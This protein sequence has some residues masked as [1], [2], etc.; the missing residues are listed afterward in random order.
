MGRSRFPRLLLPKA[1]FFRLIAGL[2]KGHNSF[3]LSV[4]GDS[5]STSSTTEPKPNSDYELSESRKPEIEAAEKIFLDSGISQQTKGLSE[6]VEE[7]EEDFA[8]CSEEENTG[9]A[10]LTTASESRMRWLRSSAKPRSRSPECDHPFRSRNERATPQLETT[11]API[12][13]VAL[14]W[15]GRQRETGR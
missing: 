12:H 3:S 13:R 8:E 9:Q 5:S 6:V 1:H 7:V 2:P 11:C 10:P 14:A 15:S 4:P